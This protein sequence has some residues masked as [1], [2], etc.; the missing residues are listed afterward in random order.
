MRSS[1]LRAPFYFLQNE[2]A[3][4]GATHKRAEYQSLLE[5]TES[6]RNIKLIFQREVNMGIDKTRIMTRN[7]RS[8]SISYHIPAIHTVN[9]LF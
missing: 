9:I 2:G 1:F 3:K 8:K 4:Y 6:W 5:R 7:K